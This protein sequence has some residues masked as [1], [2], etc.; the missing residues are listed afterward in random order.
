[1]LSAISLKWCDKA[2]VTL[3][4]GGLININVI[5]PLIE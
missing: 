4:T 1:M 2:K 3:K 5:H